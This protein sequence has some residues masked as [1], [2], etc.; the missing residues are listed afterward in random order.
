MCHRSGK[1]YQKMAQSRARRH[2]KTAKA[3][4]RKG[5]RRR[6]LSHQLAGEKGYANTSRDSY[7]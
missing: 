2:G 5:L 1:S 4:K 3:Y 6:W 7:P